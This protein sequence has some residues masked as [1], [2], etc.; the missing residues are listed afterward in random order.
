MQIV[1][2]KMY[3]LGGDCFYE[4]VEV[5]KEFLKQDKIISQIKRI[6]N[7]NRNFKNVGISDTSK[8]KF[9]FSFKSKK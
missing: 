7:D 5:G 2:T 3:C 8:C 4:Y 6:K 1:D 9:Y